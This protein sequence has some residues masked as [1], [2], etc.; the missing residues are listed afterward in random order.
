LA[1]F[2]TWPLTSSQ[3]AAQPG[4]SRKKSWA[5]RPRPLV[6]FSGTNNRL[7]VHRRP[8]GIYCRV[9]TASYV[10]VTATTAIFGPGVGSLFY[11][12]PDKLEPHTPGFILGAVWVLIILSSAAFLRYALGCPRFT[13]M[14]GTGE[15]QYFAWWGSWSS[16][17]LCRG[18]V[19]GMEVEE[20]I[21]LDEGSR[22]ANYYIV[23]TTHEERRYALCVSS[24]KQMIEALKTDLEHVM[25]G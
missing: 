8:E 19:R 12:R 20:Q 4:L 2:K 9:S 11:F 3:D 5:I 14:Y 16:L 23:V 25:V 6:G 21:F 1:Q 17:I 10:F 24:D 22:V 15:I 18:E 7:V 13:A